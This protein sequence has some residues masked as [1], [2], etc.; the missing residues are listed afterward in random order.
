MLPVLFYFFSCFYPFLPREGALLVSL[1]LF[2]LTLCPLSIKKNEDN[3][4][5]HLNSVLNPSDT[6]EKSHTT[7]IA[8]GP[9]DNSEFVS[10]QSAT[11][12]ESLSFFF[13][14]FFFFFSFNWEIRFGRFAKKKRKREREKKTGRTNVKISTLKRLETAFA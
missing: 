11:F 4:S 9:P 7:D 2:F 14:F 6:F 13:F 3:Q 1:G 8:F 5:K 12:C 10:V